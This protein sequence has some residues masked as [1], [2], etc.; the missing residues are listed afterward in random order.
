MPT[1]F[2]SARA[3]R[4][5]AAEGAEQGVQ[6]EDLYIS[7][8]EGMQLSIPAH[9]IVTRHR[10]GGDKAERRTG[11]RSYKAGRDDVREECRGW[12]LLRDM[13][14]QHS[15][16]GRL[17]SLD[18]LRAGST[19]I[20]N[21][22]TPSSEYHRQRLRAEVEVGPRADRADYKKSER[23]RRTSSTVSTPQSHIQTRVSFA[24]RTDRLPS[25]RLRTRSRNVRRHP[26]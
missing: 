16:L 12:A 14:R 11:Q 8:L 25:H 24:A 4:S 2:A 20:T 26:P 9:E 1:T 10:Q 5:A 18:A 13:L 19:G 23:S 7:S 3:G 15:D 21:H 22:T 6:A 17:A